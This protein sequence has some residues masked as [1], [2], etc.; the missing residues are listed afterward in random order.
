MKDI[1]IFPLTD[2][3]LAA[4]KNVHIAAFPNRALSFLGENAISNYYQIL[5][6][7]PKFCLRIGAHDGS[8]LVGFLVGGETS[9][10]TR[11]FVRKNFHRLVLHVLLHPWLLTKP[12]I[13][14]RVAMTLKML[15]SKKPQRPSS[16]RGNTLKNFS[17]LVIA[18]DPTVQG[19]G[20]GK[21]LMLHAE[22]VAMEH[23]YDRMLLSVDID[24]T[25]AI[26]FYEHLNWTRH[27]P[28]RWKGG[29]IKPLP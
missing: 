19:K 6:K 27:H 26:E 18:V 3:D 23:G 21:Q 11:T 29:M 2:R 10:I 20:I 15:Q 25:Q 17:I 22:R 12:I 5:L 8:R 9:G 1:Q 7:H 24:N 28:N 4:I 16:S 14:S 13:R